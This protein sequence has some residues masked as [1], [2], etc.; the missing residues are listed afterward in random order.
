MR[1]GLSGDWRS[2]TPRML[3]VLRIVAALLFLQHGF[4]KLIGVP[5]ALPPDYE[6]ASL[7]G[8]AGVV[9]TVGG[10]LLLIGLFTREAAIVLAGEL[11][12]VCFV[13]PEF[14]PLTD[15]GRVESVYALLFMYLV[16]AGP[17]TWSLDL[18]RTK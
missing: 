9:E 10:L 3:S 11:A 1:F 16:F 17:G 14:Y 4:S 13:R 8:L 6:F 18:R 12:V 2:W 7:L 5:V 15:G